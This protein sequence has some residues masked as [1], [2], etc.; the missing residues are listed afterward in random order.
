MLHRTVLLVLGSLF[1]IAF[2]GARA[3]TSLGTPFRDGVILQSGIAVPVWGR[4]EPGEKIHVEFA[5]QVRDATTDEIGNWKIELSP[6]PTNANPARLLVRGKNEIVIQDILV[7]E[8]WLCSGQSNMN[9]NLRQAANAAQEIAAANHPLIRHFTVQGKVSDEPQPMALGEWKTCSPTT[10]GD[11][12]AVGYF[13]A[14]DLHRTLGVPVGIIKAT[15]GGS[16]IEG[17]L[18]SE[19]LA[20]DPA[21]AVVATRWSQLKPRVEPGNRNQPAGLYNGLIRPLEPFALAGMVWYQGEGNHERA[22]E[23][24]K[25]LANLI[26]QSRQGFRQ[27]ELPFLL[28]QLPNYPMPQ[29]KTGRNWAWVRDAQS[30]VAASTARVAMAV[31][32]DVGDPADLHPANKAPVGARLAALALH[33]VYGKDVPDSGPV[34]IG[35][36]KEAARLRL[37]FDHAEGLHLVGNPAH[38]FEIAGEDQKFLPAEVRVDG[39]SVVVSSP[40]VPSPVAA[41]LNWINNPETYLMNAAKL[42]TSPFRTDRW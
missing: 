18:S 5:G 3:D 29:D 15:L 14:R 35:L 30:R 13:F 26:R 11:F 28:V 19:T 32:I 16:P 31:T 17:W 2:C 25:L 33:R 42:P 8:V 21:F 1:T 23:Y 37:R 34:Y 4:A 12:S 41:R 40:K 10:A 24:E 22:G 39:T 9:F 20:S 27:S 6:L 38:A 36:E 7:G